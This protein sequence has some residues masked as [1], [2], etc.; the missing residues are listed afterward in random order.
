MT[1][2]K[3]H[4]NT[5]KRYA[6]KEI[7]LESLSMRIDPEIKKSLQT[8][9]DD[10]AKR[11]NC[12]ISISKFAAMIINNYVKQQLSEQLDLIGDVEPTIKTTKKP[13]SKQQADAEKTAKTVKKTRT[14]K[15]MA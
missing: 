14:P 3:K 4:G 13:K 2:E 6:A 10:F 9:C 1:M 11:Q 15:K 5:G 8:L 12:K 7:Q